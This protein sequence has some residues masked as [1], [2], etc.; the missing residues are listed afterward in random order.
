MIHFAFGLFLIA[1]FLIS[2]ITAFAT[3]YWQ[4]LAITWLCGW[5]I[6]RS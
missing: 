5:L 2:L 6:K 1:A 4:F 3:G